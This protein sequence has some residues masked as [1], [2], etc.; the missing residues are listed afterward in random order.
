M[1]GQASKR[2]GTRALEECILRAHIRPRFEST[3]LGAIRSRDVQALVNSWSERAQARTVRR[4]FDVLRAVFNYAVEQEYLSRTPCRPV[5]L[6]EVEPLRRYVPTTAEL[7][8]LAN[9]MGPDFAAMVFLGAALGLRWGEVAG[10]RVGRIDLLRATVTVAEQITRGERGVNVCGPP[11]SRAGHRT[12]AMPAELA[13][14]LSAHLAHRGVTGADHEAFVFVAG[15]GEALRY[16]PWRKRVWNPA[17]VQCGL[18]GLTFH[19]LRRANA[20]A[21]VT[22]GIDLKTAQTRLGHSDARLTI[23]LYAQATTTAD[24]AAAATLGRRFFTRDEGPRA[25]DAP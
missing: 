17:C 6:P 15:D 1:R 21:L 19:D 3:R 20:T 25:I 14:M 10:L 24:R 2:P 9:A 5:R 7:A 16:D 11:K 8:A 4:Q 18:E 13:A 12:I 22:D 23:G